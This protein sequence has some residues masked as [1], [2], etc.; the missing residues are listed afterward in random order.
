MPVRQDERV[1]LSLGNQLG[2][3]DCFPEGRCRR[4]DTAI[5]LQHC[6]CSKLLIL[7]QHPGEGN[8]DASSR[9][10]LV[11]PLDLNASFCKQG[12]KIHF[13]PSR[14]AKALRRFLSAG[15]DRAV[16]RRSTC[17]WPAPGK[18]QDS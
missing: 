14:Q 12:R 6:L 11:G 3:D 18:T 2:C 8:L 17:A 5:M 1:G 15:D 10:G 7:P 13:A 4:Q 9:M 16:F